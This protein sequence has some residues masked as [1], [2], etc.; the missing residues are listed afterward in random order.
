VALVLAVCL[1]A[2][3]AVDV[4]SAR[5]AAVH[6]IGHLAAIAQ[7]LALW[8]LGRSGYRG[9]PLTTATAAGRG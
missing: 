7:A 2:T 3:S 6:E 8:A 1:A 5:T 9:A 4:A